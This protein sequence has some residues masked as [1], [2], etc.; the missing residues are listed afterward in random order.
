MDFNQSP[1]DYEIFNK[2]ANAMEVVARFLFWDPSNWTFR[3]MCT[4]SMPESPVAP[5]ASFVDL[6]S[7][8]VFA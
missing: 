3:I 1:R 6:A 7:H 5:S 2:R 8:E 4:A